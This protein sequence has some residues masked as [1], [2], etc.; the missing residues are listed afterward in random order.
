MPSRARRCLPWNATEIQEHYS[1]SRFGSDFTRCLRAKIKESDFYAY[2]IGL[3]RKQSDGD[4]IQIGLM[5]EQIS[6]FLSYD[7][8]PSGNL[9]VAE[10]GLEISW[11]DGAVVLDYKGYTLTIQA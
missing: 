5:R 10:W 8:N 3:T 2:A 6:T 4:V 9:V 1:D 7:K 11:L